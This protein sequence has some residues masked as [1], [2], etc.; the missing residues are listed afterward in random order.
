MGQSPY[1]SFRTTQT[2]RWSIPLAD[3]DCHVIIIPRS[4][5]LLGE[6]MHKGPVRSHDGDSS[7]PR[8]SGARLRGSRLTF[9]ILARSKAPEVNALLKAALSELDPGIQLGAV[10]AIFARQDREGLTEAIGS[11]H[12]LSSGAVSFLVEHTDKL[13]PLFRDLMS[14]PQVQIRANVIDLVCQRNQVKLAYLLVRALSDPEVRIVGRALSGLERLT[15]RYH[16][17]VEATRSGMLDLSRSE[18]EAKKFALVDPLLTRLSPIR[19]GAA[20]DPDIL[21]RLLELSMGLD[22]R[23]DE[24]L[25]RILTNPHDARSE[26]VMHLLTASSSPQVISFIVEMLRDRGKCLRALTLLE[27]RG[28]ADFVRGLLQVDRLFTNAGLREALGGLNHICWL[29]SYATEPG[30]DRVGVASE[31]AEVL[32]EATNIIR[33]I[34]LLI[35]SS[36]P[37]RGVLEGIVRHGPN[38]LARSSA[39]ITLKALA[40]GRTRREISIALLDTEKN[41][42]AESRQAGKERLVGAEEKSRTRATPKALWAR[43]GAAEIPRDAFRQF[44]EDYDRLTPDVKKLA[45]TTLKR[46]DADLDAELRQVLSSLDSH[47]R[48]RA[49]HIVQ[50]LNR[51][52][53][54]QEVLLEL[55]SDPDERVR[56]TVV[57]TLAILDNEPAVRALLTAVTD[58]DRRVVANTV[59]ALEATGFSE[60]VGLIKILARHPN[61]RIR[62]NAVKALLL[63]NSP[64]AEQILREMLTSSV[65]LMRLSAT[66]IMGEVDHPKRADWLRRLARE[67]SSVR[68]RQK[69]RDILGNEK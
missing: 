59:E 53:R 32:G 47:D 4:K 35:L 18:L 29:E 12:L 44:F 8:H 26:Q 61:N 22:S 49:V 58:F 33:A 9:S 48:L 20:E 38:E 57:K 16:Q 63:L 28:K 14:S 52:Q 50:E 7:R 54:L 15:R 23:T 19:S 46:L 21:S 30:A 42:K 56:A 11:A 5:T 69:A 66:W 1:D 40:E 62:A 39:L 65:E 6:K 68:V 51:E 55:V 37:P 25:Y 2:V 34:H 67:D 60:L 3:F 10:G 41:L 43:P 36:V 45:A 27:R 24:L 64:G 31:V 13:L 17:Q